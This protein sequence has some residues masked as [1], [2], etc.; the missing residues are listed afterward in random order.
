MHRCPECDGWYH[1]DDEQCCDPYVDDYDDDRSG[2]SGEPRRTCTTCN[3]A[4]NIFDELSEE[5]ICLHIADERRRQRVPV[6]AVA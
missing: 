4:N 6:V 3:T 1:E 2:R 5:F